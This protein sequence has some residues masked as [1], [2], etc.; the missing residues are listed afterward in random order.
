MIASALTS[1]PQHSFSYYID[2]DE[3]RWNTGREE[4]N[5]GYRP[6]YKERLLPLFHPWTTSR[7]F[8]TD[9]VTQME[10]VIRDIECHHHEVAIK[11]QRKSTSASTPW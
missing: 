6:R 10:A 11:Q 8:C 1:A 5:L 9:M 7:T 3:G 4:H 2:S